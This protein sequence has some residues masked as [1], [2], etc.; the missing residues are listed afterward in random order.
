ITRFHAMGSQYSVDL[1]RRTCTCRIWQLS[2]IPCKHECSAIFHQTLMPE[3]MVHPYY[4]VVA[5]KQVYEPAIL[6]I[7]GELLWS[8]TLFI[9]PLPP[10]FGRGPG[11]PAGARRREPDEQPV[12]NKKRKSKKPVKQVKLKRQHVWK[13]IPAEVFSLQ[14][15]KRGGSKG[16]P[17]PR[18]HS[19]YV[20]PHKEIVAASGTVANANPV[21]L[22]PE[23]PQEDT[24]QENEPT[25]TILTELGPAITPT[26][27]PG[28]SIYEQLQMAH[29]N[30]SMLPP[31]TLQ[32]RL[33]IKAPPPMT[34]IA[35]MPS[36][37][38][39]QQ[40]Q[41]PKTSLRWV[42]KSL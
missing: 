11:R 26:S 38:L 41:L 6:P 22:P 18:K 30:I 24:S 19:V 17:K 39:D 27:Q 42:D 16:N 1:E 23:N 28:P 12:K 15:H 10:N 3:D 20:D 13:N 40:F 32:P 8:E 34:G 37:Q 5:Y 36:S 35:F 31:V 9:P 7:S 33:S 2:G 4:T 14:G 29:N 25:Q 21:I